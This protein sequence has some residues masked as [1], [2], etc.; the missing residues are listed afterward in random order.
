M[1]HKARLMPAVRLLDPAGK[2]TRA[3]RVSDAES[4][5]CVSKVCFEGRQ[6]NCPG[7]KA[8]P[9]APAEKCEMKA[10][11]RKGRK[12]GT[13]GGCCLFTAKIRGHSRRSA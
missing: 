5:A 4:R 10:D 2:H 6:V 11:G 13:G 3:V 8:A 9:Q 12:N 1:Q 7:K